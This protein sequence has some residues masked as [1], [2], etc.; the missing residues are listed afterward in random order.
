MS[1]LW[2]LAARRDAT[3]LNYNEKAP[4]RYRERLSELGFVVGA[5]IHC[6][7]ITPFGGPRV[8]RVGGCIYSIDRELAQMINVGIEEQR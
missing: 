2:E 8:Y 7:R 5:V 4:V 1:N 6:L 3:V